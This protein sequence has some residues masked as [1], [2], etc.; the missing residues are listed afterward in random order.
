MKL[1]GRKPDGVPVDPSLGDPRAAAL[2]EAVEADDLDGVRAVLADPATPEERE[3]LTTTL[4]DHPGHME[5]FEAWLEQEHDRPAAWLARGAYGVGWAWDARGGGYAELVGEE[6]WDEF[7]RRLTRAEDDLVRAA[8]MD[9]ADAVP[10]THLITAARGLE[11][12]AEELWRR[13]EAAHARRPWLYEAHFQSLQFVCEK[14]FGSDEESLA[15]ARATAR[16]AP[17]GASVRALVPQAHIEIWLDMHRREGE[18]PEAYIRREE[19]REEIHEAARGSVLADGFADEL[20]N[21]PALNT[22]AMGLWLAGDEATARALVGRL[23]RR[24]AEAPWNYLEEPG[25]VYADLLAD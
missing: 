12:P 25:R 23:G 4:V 16:D 6:A 1:F 21:V 18:D 15:F 13:H 14:W 9:P 17:A 11:V 3:R 24:R 7:F 5:V 19:V 8:E 20:A 2:I 10:W 22:F